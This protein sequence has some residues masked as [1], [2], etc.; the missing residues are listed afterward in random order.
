MTPTAAQQ[1]TWEGFKR[2]AQAVELLNKA[3]YHAV[4]LAT[5][6]ET[7]AKERGQPIA[8]FQPLH[9]Q[10]E[11]LSQIDTRLQMVVA[12][13]ELEKLGLRFRKDGDFDILA[14]SDMTD[15]EL[16]KYKLGLGWIIMAVGVVVV[17]AAVAWIA[18][19]RKENHDLVEDYNEL[20]EQTDNRY[21]VDPSSP[22]CVVW[23]KRKG[24]RQYE[25]KQD[26]IEE[27]TAKASQIG[28]TIVKGAQWGL[29][30]AIPLL[31]WLLFGRK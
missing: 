4:D 10:A 1:R 17:G 26:A 18:L 7:F 19:L 15:D 22:T 12:A 9:K 2:E 11:K 21:C 31:A 13:V 16:A 8:A 24:E 5:M 28:K 25:K 30:V 23:L 6:T 14:P 27:L 3:L 29:V 20:L